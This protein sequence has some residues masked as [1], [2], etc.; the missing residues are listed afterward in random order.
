MDIFQTIILS[1]VE[2]ISE[3]LPISST[4]HLVLI[5]TILKIQQTEFVKSFEI[6]IQLG[7]ICAI[8]FL[9]RKTLLTNLKDWQRIII[10][11]IPTGILGF[12]LYKIIKNYLLG[13]DL[14]IVA[15]LFTG[16]IVMILL[17]KIYTEKS[18]PQDK[19]ESMS[20]KQAFGIGLIQ[21]WLLQQV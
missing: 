17:E 5:S 6:F 13:N 21:S 1:I 4:G 3:F 11:F 20:Y 9:Y 15:S 18:V 2:G 7:A 12:T 16:G 10:A 14:I 8:I 19:I